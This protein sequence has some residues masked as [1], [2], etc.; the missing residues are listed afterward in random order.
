MGKFK[1]EA[2]VIELANNTSYGLAAGLHSSK[3]RVCLCDAVSTERKLDHV[4]RLHLGDQDH[5]MRVSSA[6][7]AGTVSDRVVAIQGFAF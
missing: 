6:L 5:C 2:E 7:E 4:P 1:T 3:S